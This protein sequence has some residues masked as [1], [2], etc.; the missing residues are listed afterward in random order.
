MNYSSS[1]PFFLSIIVVFLDNERFHAPQLITLLGLLLTIPV[2]SRQLKEFPLAIFGCLLK[3]PTPALKDWLL[4]TI[5]D[6]MPVLVDVRM[7]L[8]WFYLIKDHCDLIE[9]IISSHNWPEKNRSILANL[10]NNLDAIQRSFVAHNKGFEALS[11]AII[12]ELTAGSKTTADFAAVL[13]EVKEQRELASKLRKAKL[14]DFNK[15][16]SLWE[17]EFSMAESN[18]QWNRHVASIQDQ[19]TD[20]SSFK[21]RLFIF[22]PCCLLYEVPRLLSPSSFTATE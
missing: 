2:Q 9:Q 7:E 11:E 20:V 10:S 8:T 21:P 3:I 19:M 13:S 22:S 6:L 12:P 1:I 5:G 17:L 18:I 14:D 16:Q 4:D 15:E